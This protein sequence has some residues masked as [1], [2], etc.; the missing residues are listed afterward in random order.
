[1]PSSTAEDLAEPLIPKEESPATGDVGENG[2]GENERAEP[3]AQQAQDDPEAPPNDEGS[4]VEEGRGRRVERA[5]TTAVISSSDPQQFTRPS[6]RCYLVKELF[7]LLGYLLHRPIFSDATPDNPLRVQV[8]FIKFLM[9]TLL[10][11]IATH[12]VVVTLVRFLLQYTLC[13][14]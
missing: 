3:A 10:G 6:G 8:R 12:M 9:V 13:V 1:M 11:I 14:L 4:L 5:R 7:H 2:I